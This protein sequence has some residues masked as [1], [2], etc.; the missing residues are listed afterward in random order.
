MPTHD[1]GP[2][3]PGPPAL[4]LTREDAAAALGI[5]VRT[6]DALTRDRDARLPRLRIGARVLY[7][8]DELRRWLA[9]RSQVETRE[10][11][12]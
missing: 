9:E 1:P 10:V 5:S 8:T 6:L 4:A 3:R 11:S 7:P 12:R 2:V